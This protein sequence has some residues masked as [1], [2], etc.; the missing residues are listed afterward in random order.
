M[1]H[2]VDIFSNID[3]TDSYGQDIFNMCLNFFFFLIVFY[4][5]MDASHPEIW[6]YIHSH[7]SCRP[8]GDCGGS[9]D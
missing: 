8:S 3:L 9:G 7:N 6:F 2:S 4:S 5:G 1:T